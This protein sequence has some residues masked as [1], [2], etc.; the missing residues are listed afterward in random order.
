M[1]YPKMAEF[2]LKNI[3]PAFQS[4][5]IFSEDYMEPK[6]NLPN[7]LIV[8]DEIGPRESLRMIL[9]PNYNVFTA[10]SGN[11]AIQMIQQIAMDVITLDLK[12]PGLSGID[13]L[14]E[15][16][17]VDSDVMI[18]IITG[19]G[20]LKSAIEAIRYGVFDYIPKPFN[21]PEIISIIDKSVQ[22][23]KLNL[24]IKEVVS[25]FNDTPS[26]KEI[27]LNSDLPIQNGFKEIADNKWNGEGLSDSQNFLKFAKVLAHTL[28]EKDPY[29]SGHSER[30]CYY[31]D[32]IS[33][34]LSLPPKERNEIQVAAYLHDVGK[35]G[36]SNRFINKKGT[37]THIDWAIIKQHTKKSIELL[38]P[39][40]LSSN[41]LSY[42]QYHHERF[43]GE[44]Y[45]EGLSADQIP[46]GARI[47]AVSDAY[48]SMT[49]NHPYRKPLSNEEAK[50]ELL[51][52]AGKQFDPNLVS[53]FLD[54]LKEME[55]VFLVRDHLKTPSISY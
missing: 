46:L 41:V 28:E 9:K 43:D 30:V 27:V 39:L 32:F 24:K 55:E 54:V 10:E 53:I 14:K 8:D 12:M 35:I 33:K 7:I 1:F 17:M 26:L 37:L 45:P 34:R 31:S 50:N 3:R 2:L 42:I 16:R 21:V 51:K 11:A 25:K 22:R 36:I 20:T 47:I 13:T 4:C 44:G 49:S 48:D 38:V 6:S 23:R 40:N 5:L 15:I 18:I 19:Y 29:T 52:C